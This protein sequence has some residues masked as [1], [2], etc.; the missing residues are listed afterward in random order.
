[1]RF[2]TEFLDCYIILWKK[3]LDKNNGI[4][5]RNAARQNTFFFISLIRQFTS[6]FSRFLFLCFLYC[7][8]L[9][10]KI[11]VK[12]CLKICGVNLVFNLECDSTSW[13]YLTCWHVIL[14]N[15]LLPWSQSH[16]LV[17]NTLLKRRSLTVDW[18]FKI[19]LN[20]SEIFVKFLYFRLIGMTFY[21][22]SRFREKIPRVYLL[23]MPL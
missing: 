16:D 23:C 17:E 9:K 15:F 12:V 6:C 19:D 7:F 2:V 18:P 10:Y 4:V 8:L 3:F 11:I 20:Y 21:S 22:I 14:T 1:M 13:F 5:E